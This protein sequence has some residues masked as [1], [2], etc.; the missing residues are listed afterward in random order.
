MHKAFHPWEM[1]CEDFLLFHVMNSPIPLIF[2]YK[3]LEDWL[4]RVMSFTFPASLTFCEVSLYSGDISTYFIICFFFFTLLNT[5]Y[6]ADG[7]H[8][9]Q[10]PMVKAYR[11]FLAFAP[12]WKSRNINANLPPTHHII[13]SLKVHY[14]NEY[15][16]TWERNVEYFHRWFTIC[17]CKENTVEFF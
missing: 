15:Q 4:L 1:N 10:T 2:S 12:G 14:L 6:R 13:S 5:W 17:L 8:E 3:Q 11:C 9:H 7:L 16:M